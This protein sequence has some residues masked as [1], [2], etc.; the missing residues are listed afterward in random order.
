MNAQTEQLAEMELSA[1]SVADYLTRHPGFFEQHPELLLELRLP[2]QSGGTISLV[3]R[4]VSNLREQSNR[5][6]QQLE[7]L[8]AVA[9]ENR[10][11]EQRLHQLTLSLI[12]AVDFDEVVNVLQDRLPEEFRAEAV[13]LHLF[14]AAEVGG[15]TNPD[16]DG[17]RG[18]LDQ[19]TPRCSPLP[20]KQLTY[21]FGPQAEDI[22]SSALIPV[23]GQG[24]LGLLAFGSHDKQR[25]H[26][27]MGTDYL[28]R[29][30][31]IVSKTLQVVSEP[32]V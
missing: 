17:F 30:G 25:F 8:I 12:A 16:L 29:L 24:L 1:Q 31:E 9:K 19:G 22:H 11:V 13:E 5:Y 23:I 20:Q 3:E 21:L 7:Q 14:S 6:R 4:Q 15:E 10:E 28:T 27:E 32:G 26:P 18:F 2:H